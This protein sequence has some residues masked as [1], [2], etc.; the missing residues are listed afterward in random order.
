MYVN[1]YLLYVR[2]A[3]EYLWEMF[4]FSGIEMP[5]LSAEA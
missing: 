3:T 1:T 4:Q 5:V 2:Y